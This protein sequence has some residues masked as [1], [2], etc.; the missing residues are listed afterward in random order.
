[1]TLAAISSAEARRAG[2]SSKEEL[3]AELAVRKAGTVYR[4]DLHLAGPDPRIALRGKSALTAAEVA[5]LRARLDRLDAA[6]RHG[7]WTQRTLAII[8]ARPKQRAADLALELDLPKDWLKVSIRKVKNL[9]LTISHEPGYELS[10]RGKRLLRE[11]RG[12]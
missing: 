1:M 3:L 9:G 11:L 2:Y 8:Q 4:I 6:S 12:G 10:P 5:A 7:V